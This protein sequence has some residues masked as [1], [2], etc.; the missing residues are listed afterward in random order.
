M[1]TGN[2]FADAIPP[3]YGERFETI[4]SH[5][6]I[7]IERIVSSAAIASSEYVQ[8]QD[9]WVVLVQ[10]NALLQVAGESVALMPGDHLFLPA[11]VPHSVER[12][13]EG[14]IWLAV[15]VHPEQAAEAAL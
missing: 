1:R 4:L 13:S 11:G 2:L 6:N 9:E 3:K 7:V 5:R 12:V 10:G 15:H 14:A 8:A